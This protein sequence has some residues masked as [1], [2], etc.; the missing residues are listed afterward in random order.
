MGGA[1][2]FLNSDIVQTGL[3]IGGDLLGGFLQGKN[4]Q[5]AADDLINAN[6]QAQGVSKEA[7][8]QGRSDI[9]GTTQ[10]GLTDLM[11]GFQGAINVSEGVGQAE[12][13]ARALS[14]ALGPEAQAQA[15][16]GFISSPGQDFLRDQ[17][18]QA[19]LRNQNA[20]GGLGGGRVK[21]ALQEEAFGRAATTQQQHINNLMQLGIPEQQRNANISNLLSSGGGQ[22]A[23]FRQGAGVN[24]A[25]LALGGAAQ[26]IPLIT[27]TGQAQAAGTLGFGS[28]L[29]Q[30][31][32]NAAKTL[33]AFGQ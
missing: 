24:L 30:G 28:A 15:Q 27:G 10:P 9:L 21:S 17:Q 14:G 18:E 26:Q 16:A 11:T 1:L 23:N 32:G 31:V 6:I 33:G 3:S 13:M 5:D 12:Q 2:D 8:A 29:Q 19:L 22:L 7:I 20:I 25:N 4:T